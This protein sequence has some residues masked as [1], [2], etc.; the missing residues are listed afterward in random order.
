MKN[1]VLVDPLGL[2]TNDPSSTSFQ[3]PL[4]NIEIMIQPR[5]DQILQV[6]FRSFGPFEWYGHWKRKSIL[7]LL[8]VTT[9]FGRSHCKWLHLKVPRTNQNTCRKHVSAYVQKVLGLQRKHI[10][11]ATFLRHYPEFLYFGQFLT[12]CDEFFGLSKTSSCNQ[13]VHTQYY[14]RMHY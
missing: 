12:R 3:C 7:I 1:V 13:Q 8:Q 6:I 9:V 4:S 5:T 11:P 14:L 2:L 10:Q